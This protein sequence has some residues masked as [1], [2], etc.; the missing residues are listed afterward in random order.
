MSGSGGDP[1]HDGDEDTAYEVSDADDAEVERGAGAAHLDG[2]LVVE[3]LLQADDGEDVAE[4]GEDVLRGEPP[5]RHGEGGLGG[6][7]EAVLRRDA[8]APG[9]EQ[10]GDHHREGGE[11]EPG[12]DSLEH[13]DAG[14]EAGE[15]PGGGDEEAVVEGDGDEDCGAGN[16][17]ERRRR[18]VE[19]GDGAVQ[20][21]ALLGEESAVLGYDGGEGEAAQPYGDE[22]EEELHLLHL[23][24]AA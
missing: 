23:A 20:G 18:E 22:T 6:V 7:E 2:H 5:D 1:L 4:S 21:G 13:G 3:E 15:V 12:A 9:F 17:L 10:P 19:G 14:G 8:E 11:E 16:D 24:H